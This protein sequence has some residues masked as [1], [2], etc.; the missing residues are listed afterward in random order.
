MFLKYLELLEAKYAEFGEICGAHMRHV[1]AVGHW[2]S[3]FLLQR[4]PK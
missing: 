4:N 2:F 3:T 1:Y